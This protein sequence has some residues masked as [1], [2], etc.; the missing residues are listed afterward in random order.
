[1]SDED[2]HN[3]RETLMRRFVGAKLV[4]ITSTDWDE[5]AR[6]EGRAVI[7]LFDNGGTVTFPIDDDGFSFELPD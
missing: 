7:L 3:L 2:P 1:M 5:V 6:G 4:D